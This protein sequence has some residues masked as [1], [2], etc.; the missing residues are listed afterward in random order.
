MKKLFKG[1][2]TICDVLILL[3]LYVIIEVFLIIMSF[4][5]TFIGLFKKK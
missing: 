1:I 3:V 5:D 4:I 2:L